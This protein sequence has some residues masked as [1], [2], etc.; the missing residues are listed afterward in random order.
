MSVSPG[1]GDLEPSGH[2]RRGGAPATTRGDVVDGLL[3]GIF[4]SK[5]DRPARRGAES[6]PKTTPPQA[7]LPAASL[8]VDLIGLEPTSE[9]A[10]KQA[11]S[12]ETPSAVVTPVVTFSANS[13]RGCPDLAAIAALWERLTP[14]MRAAVRSMAEAM[15]SNHPL[16]KQQSEQNPE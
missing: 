8:E 1:R 6:R 10:G 9:T 14:A 16:H 7:C 2:P 12:V 3:V 15:A 11:D 5:A 4:L 13:P